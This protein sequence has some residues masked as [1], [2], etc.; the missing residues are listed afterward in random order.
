M[1][2]EFKRHDLNS[3][4]KKGKLKKLK[5]KILLTDGNWIENSENSRFKWFVINLLF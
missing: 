1:K 2:T 5:K 4:V 3:L